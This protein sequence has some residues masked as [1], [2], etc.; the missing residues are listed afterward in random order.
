MRILLV[1]YIYLVI[2]SY[3]CLQSKGLGAKITLGVRWSSRVV[4]MVDF[5]LN[6]KLD[7]CLY[8]KPHIGGK[9]AYGPDRE[10]IF[11]Q[12]TP[13][14]SLSQLLLLVLI[15]QPELYNLL[16]ILLKS[17][18]RILFKTVVHYRFSYAY[19]FWK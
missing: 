13:R 14:H 17:N 12:A 18:F 19:L 11:L 5:M 9:K 10:K 3:K 2:L 8:Q 7:N 15:I 4:I 6:G 1:N 16:H